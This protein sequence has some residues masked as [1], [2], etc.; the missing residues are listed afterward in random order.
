MINVGGSLLFL[1]C[2][3]NGNRAYEFEG[4]GISNAGGDAVIIGC[5]FCCINKYDR[6]L[7]A[8]FLL[9]IIKF[10]FAAVIILKFNQSG[11]YFY[12]WLTYLHC[13]I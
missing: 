3:F 11:I 9:L 5:R 4:G 8:P 12:S 6:T 10:T 2:L 13:A 1:D 7:I